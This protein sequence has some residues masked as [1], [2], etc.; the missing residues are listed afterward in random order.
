MT[1][2]E[3]ALNILEILN[4]AE[5]IIPTVI[6]EPKRNHR[7]RKTR[8]AKYQQ[9]AAFVNRHN[10]TDE[11]ARSTVTKAERLQGKTYRRKH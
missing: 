7:V 11:K 3:E 4:D 1:S 6:E 10:L 2:L 8:D 9:R 5:P